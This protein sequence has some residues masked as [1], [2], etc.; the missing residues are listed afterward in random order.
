M[1]LKNIAQKISEDTFKIIGYPVS[2]SDDKGYLIGV[3][4]QSRL[5]LYDKLFAE[6]IKKQ[7]MIYWDEE[8]V[9][10]LDNI[11]PGVAAPIIVNNKVLGAVGVLG[12]TGEDSETTSYIKLVKNHIEMICHD[13]IKKEMKSLETSTIDTLIHY[14][15]HFDNT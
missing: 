5:G 6:V 3:N 14:I 11:F 9:V 13:K 7:K 4:D 15:L 1:V 8:D 2:I 10:E 12:K